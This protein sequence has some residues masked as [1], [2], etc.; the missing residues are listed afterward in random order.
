LH[1][2]EHPQ[3][4]LISTIVFGSL[5]VRRVNQSSELAVR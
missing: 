4:V 2:S 1:I 3:T 5:S